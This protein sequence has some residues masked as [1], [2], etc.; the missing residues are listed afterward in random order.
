MPIGKH[1]VYLFI[2]IALFV[3]FLSAGYLALVEQEV[4]SAGQIGSSPA[5][6]QRLHVQPIGCWYYFGSD[7]LLGPFEERLD[8]MSIGTFMSR[9]YAPLFAEDPIMIRG[10]WRREEDASI[11]LFVGNC[12]VNEIRYDPSEGVFVNME[13]YRYVRVC[14]RDTLERIRSVYME[15]LPPR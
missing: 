10:F 8:L 15:P 3:A 2:F 1:V 5:V 12:M 11:G 4:R 7:P 9:I 6:E 14:S 13:G